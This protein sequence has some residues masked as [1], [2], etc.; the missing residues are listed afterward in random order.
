[1]ELGLK[2]QV[3]I[4]NFSMNFSDTFIN[5]NPSIFHMH[6]DRY[7]DSIHKRIQT[8]YFNVS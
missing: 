7:P 3:Q 2:I 4:Q 6:I 8:D 1:M 5:L